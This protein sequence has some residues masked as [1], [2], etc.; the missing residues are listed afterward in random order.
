MVTHDARVL[1]A[2]IAMSSSMLRLR[3]TPLPRCRAR[4]PR[5]PHRA[6]PHPGALPNVGHRRHRARTGAH[7]HRAWLRVGPDPSPLN[8]HAPRTEPLSIRRSQTSSPL[9][10][11]RIEDA[12]C[13]S[14]GTPNRPQCLT[15]PVDPAQRDHE[16]LREPSRWTARPRPRRKRA[17]GTYT[18]GGDVGTSSPRGIDPCRECRRSAPRT[19]HCRRSRSPR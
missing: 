1:T 5:G 14:R 9:R 13:S 4:P 3:D 15:M 18:Q 8:R 19:T 17:P 10:L 2:P 12:T 16:A 11:R 7:Q 6:R